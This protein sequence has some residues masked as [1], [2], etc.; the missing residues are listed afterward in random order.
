MA[1]PKVYLEFHTL[2]IVVLMIE[3]CKQALGVE[4]SKSTRDV[5]SPAVTTRYWLRDAIW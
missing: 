4:Q 3:S 2:V 5:N 1:R